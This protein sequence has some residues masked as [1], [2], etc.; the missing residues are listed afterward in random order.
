MLWKGL[1]SIVAVKLHWKWRTW[2]RQVTVIVFWE[3]YNVQTQLLPNCQM[4]W[5]TKR[6][7][8]KVKLSHT[9]K[10]Y[11]WRKQ[12]HAEQKILGQ[13]NAFSCKWN[14]ARRKGHQLLT[15]PTRM[16]LLMKEV[17]FFKVKNLPL[18]SNMKDLRKLLPLVAYTITMPLA[19][20]MNWSKIKQAN[21][22]VA[23]SD[24]NNIMTF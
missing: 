11:R 23:N 20:P 15:N 1:K 4:I 14:I 19:L 9:I 22:R 2:S 16:V 5:R 18:I 17:T 7:V 21:F 24:L 12:I 6:A 10:I 3:L 13:I 8:S